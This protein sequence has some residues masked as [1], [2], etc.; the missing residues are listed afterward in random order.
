MMNPVHTGFA[1]NQQLLDPTGLRVVNA[2]T[3][4]NSLR[5]PVRLGLV[6][7]IVFGIG[8]IGWGGFVPLAGGAIAP[9]VIS[10]DGDR[11]TVQHLEGG[12]IAQLLVR[13][14]DVVSSGQPLVVL[15]SI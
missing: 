13:D 1:N 7:M 6:V 3:L 12:I 15:E 5:R 10:P 9:G 4:R 14:G 11:K 2:V 8:V